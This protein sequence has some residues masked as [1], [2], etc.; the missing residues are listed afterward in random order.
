M[1]FYVIQFA[2]HASF[3]WNEKRDKGNV[4]LYQAE[5]IQ[6]KVHGTMTCDG[7]ILY[8]LLAGGDYHNVCYFLFSHK[9]ILIS[10]T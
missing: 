6:S 7:L 5:E 3:S 9:S 4:S 10:S 2:Y 8:A 1:L